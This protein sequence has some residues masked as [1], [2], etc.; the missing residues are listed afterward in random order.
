M[1][2][3]SFNSSVSLFLVILMT[4]G[5][6]I[7]LAA[8]ISALFCLM[9]WIGSFLSLSKN[10]SWGNFLGGWIGVFSFLFLL[11]IF[12]IIRYIVRCKR[13]PFFKEMSERT[14]IGWEDYK[15]M[16]DS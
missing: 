13:D 11:N 16:K 4:I 5:K 9:K 14:G 15:R 12:S 10:P 6:N 7:A 8:V 2:R 3:K 1:R